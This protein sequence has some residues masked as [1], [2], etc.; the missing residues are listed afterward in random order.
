MN[1]FEETKRATFDSLYKNNKV[2]FEQ[3]FSAI[4][5][6]AILG[7]TSVVVEVG[8]EDMANAQSLLTGLVLVGYGAYKY[9]DTEIYIDWL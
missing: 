6:Q 3:C 7:F 8:K 9:S 1:H 4:T 5:S 2:L